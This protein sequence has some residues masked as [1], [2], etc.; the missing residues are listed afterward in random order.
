MSTALL[1]TLREAQR[2]GFFGPGPVEE[3]TAHAQSFVEVLRDLPLGARL[4]DL[5]S[6]GGLPGLVLAEALPDIEILL[7]DRREKRTDFL[8]RVV[9][10]LGFEQVTVRAGDV[11]VLVREVEAGEVDRFDAVTA[12]G[13]GPPTVTLRLAARLLAPAGRIVVS[14]PPTG[15]RWPPELLTELGLVGER[16]GGVRVFRHLPR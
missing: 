3:A 8:E 10:R 11:A 14:E 1:E 4:V 6:G 5:G 2:F 9:R 7:V 16:H 12:R 15:D 13:F